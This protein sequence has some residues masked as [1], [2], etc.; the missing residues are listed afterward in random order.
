MI[1]K[2]P[3]IIKKIEEEVKITYLPTGKVIFQSIGGR[4]Y[5]QVWTSE[6]M[7]EFRSMDQIKGARLLI[8]IL[9]ESSKEMDGLF[10]GTKHKEKYPDVD[11]K[12]R[13]RKK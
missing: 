6:G 13:K 5:L 3:D 2:I 10:H 1:D 12:G 4:R 8:H 11:E 7:R 9:C